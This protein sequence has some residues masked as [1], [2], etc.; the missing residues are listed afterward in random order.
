MKCLLCPNEVDEAKAIHQEHVSEQRAHA[1]TL[2][3]WQQV[4]VQVG[5]RTVL[6]GH[7]CPDDAEATL[8]ISKAGAK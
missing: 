8:K 7:V 5:N 1:A 2:E 3:K 6:Q 4:T